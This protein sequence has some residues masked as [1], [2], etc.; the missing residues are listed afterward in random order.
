MSRQSPPASSETEPEQSSMQLLL[1]NETIEERMR[2]IDEFIEGYLEDNVGEPEVLYEAAYHL[3]RAGGKRMRSLIMVLA[4]ESVGGRTLDALPLALAAELLQTASLIH[5]DI[6][7]EDSFRRGVK[8]VHDVFGVKMAILAGDLLISQ[9]VR[10]LGK[11][12]SSNL[13]EH[14][15]EGGGKMCE[16]EATDLLMNPNHEEAYNEETYLRMIERKTVAFVEEAARTGVLVGRGSDEQMRSLLE[17]ARSLGFAFQIRDD[18][19]DLEESLVLSGKTHHSDLRLQRGNYVV[20][21][22]LSM[23]D[24]K[25]RR[26]LLDS[27]L[28]RETEVV[29]EML[30]NTHAFQRARREAQEYVQRAKR[31]LRESSLG[32]TNA[33]L[34]IADFVLDRFH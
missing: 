28:N 1:Q 6:I 3:I 20:L 27:L 25:G 29:L 13:L 5:D 26:K 34:K 12:G 23:L 33:L 11:H 4:C 8:T 18:I 31:A 32:N 19:L 16:G 22:A 14:M 21:S 17:Y 10:L 30:R 9:A 2:M 15:G 24:N 7:D